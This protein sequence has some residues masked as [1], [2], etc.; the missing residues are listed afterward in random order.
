MVKLLKHVLKLEIFSTLQ[1]S[2]EFDKKHVLN[3]RYL[4]NQGRNEE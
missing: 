2:H 3:S 4:E 1:S